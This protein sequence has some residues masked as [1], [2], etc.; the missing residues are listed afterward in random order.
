[1]QLLFGLFIIRWP[2]GRAIFEC[3]SNKIITF[4]NFVKVGSTF[5]YSSVLADGSNFVFSVSIS[6]CALRH[7]LFIS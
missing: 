5:A 4:L 7:K 3:I 6:I 1:M 2:V